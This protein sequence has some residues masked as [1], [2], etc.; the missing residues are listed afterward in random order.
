M[1]QGI[2]VVTP[3]HPARLANGMTKRAVGSAL[4]QTWQPTTLVVEVD[5][6]RRGAPAT[7]DAGL[8]KVTTRWTAFLDSDDEMLPHHLDR[9]L[10]CA[11]ET[12]ADYVYAWYE[13]AGGKDPFPEHFGKPWDPDAPRMTT[14]T[15]LVATELAQQVR[16]SNHDLSGVIGRDREAGEDWWFTLG[17]NHLRAKIVHLPERTWRWN[18]HGQNSSGRPGIGDAR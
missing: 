3:T 18:H 15:V 5:K 9:L 1:E 2:T 6:H 16:F 4:A 8:A 17:C 10:S 7:R 13:V 14:I 12:G 11:R